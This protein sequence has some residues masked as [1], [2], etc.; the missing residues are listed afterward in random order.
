MKKLI[1][2]ILLFPSICFANTWITR[3]ELLLKEYYNNNNSLEWKIGKN[4][5]VEFT[6][7]S[8]DNVSFNLIN[9]PHMFYE[10]RTYEGT[11]IKYKKFRL[12]YSP[13]KFKDCY[14]FESC[15]ITLRVIK[16]KMNVNPSSSWENNPGG[17]KSRAITIS[18]I[19]KY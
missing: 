7:D 1:F 14:I 2:L 4:I 6:Y 17:L 15:K 19:A 13:L 9:E 10:K 11:N 5:S 12:N 18:Y 3:D 16:I 8:F